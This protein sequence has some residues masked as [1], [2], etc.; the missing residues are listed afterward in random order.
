MKPG[1]QLIFL[2]ES[3]GIKQTISL[4]SS[5]HLHGPHNCQTQTRDFISNNSNIQELQFSKVIT[6]QECSLSKRYNIFAFIDGREFALY[7]GNG[8]ISF[9]APS[10]HAYIFSL[11]II[12]YYLSP[13]SFSAVGPFNLFFLFIVDFNYLL[14]VFKYLFLTVFR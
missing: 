3:A 4:I 10:V 2:S 5:L 7:K 11:Q 12:Q 14:N 1:M 8:Y 6:R 9:D 13:Y